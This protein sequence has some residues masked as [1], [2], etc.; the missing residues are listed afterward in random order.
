L[1]IFQSRDSRDSIPSG[2]HP[3]AL[4]YFRTLDALIRVLLLLLQQVSEDSFAQQNLPAV[5]TARFDQCPV[6]PLKQ[7][8]F[9]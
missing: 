1:V 9:E 3:A 2:C 4:F 7:F 5:L 8:P 6:G